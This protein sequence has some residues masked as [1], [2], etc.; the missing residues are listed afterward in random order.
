MQTSAAELPEL[1]T[2]GFFDV[3]N[4]PPHD[5]WIAFALMASQRAHASHLMSWVPAELLQP[6]ARG[7]RVNPEQ[8]IAWIR[9]NPEPCIAWIRGNPE[10]CIAWIQVNPEACIAWI[11]DAIATKQSR[12]HSWQQ[13]R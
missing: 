1:E 7:I 9:V 13:R 2:N 5:T 11:D 8:C 10:P 3:H 4:V 12:F 6:V